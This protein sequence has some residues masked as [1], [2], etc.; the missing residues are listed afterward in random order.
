MLRYTTARSDEQLISTLYFIY[1]VDTGIM[2]P[3]DSGTNIQRG[4]RSLPPFSQ[5]PSLIFRAHT[6][7]TAKRCV[8]FKK[9]SI[10][11]LLKN[12]INLFF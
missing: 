8:F 10:R 12:H 1:I 7:Q 2:G 9:K 6:F 5:P 3:P 11:K 4:L